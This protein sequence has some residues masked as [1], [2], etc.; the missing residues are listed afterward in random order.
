MHHRESNHLRAGGAALLFMGAASAQPV[1]PSAWATDGW[2]GMSGDGHRP[3]LVRSAPPS[4]AAPAWMATHDETD[5]PINFVAQAGLV[6]AP[7]GKFNVVVAV[8][9]VSRPG[10]PANRPRLFAFSRDEGAAVWSA[11]IPTPSFDSL[12]TPVI[13]PG[14]ETVLCASG[15]FVTAFDLAT[16]G[17]LWQRLL[18]RSVVNASPCV[19]SDLGPAD[20]L[21]ITTFDGG[22]TSA[23]LYC[24]NVDPFDAD[25][26]PFEP[27]EVVWSA[28]IGGSSGNSPAYLPA[29]L[30][31][32]GLV[33]VASVGHSQ[34]APGRV[35]AYPV[36]ETEPPAPAW[37]F[38]LAHTQGFFGGL[39]VSPGLGGAAPAVYAATYPFQG[40]IDDAHLVKLDA[41]TG[42]LRWAV[43]CNRSF[44]TPVV[45]PGGRIV[46]S[47]GI[48]FDEIGPTV[49]MFQDMGTSAYQVWDTALSTWNEL[50]DDGR[51]DI[52]EYFAVGGWTH[53]PV[54]C[55]FGGHTSLVSGVIEVDT[56]T[57]LNPR[58]YHLDLNRPPESPGFVL[59]ESAGAG[60]SP[61]FA[62]T[63][64]YSVGTAG[65]V[66]FGP[67]P[68]GL[69]VDRDGERTVDDLYAWECGVGFR[70]VNKDGAVDGGD[71]AMLIAALRVTPPVSAKAVLP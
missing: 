3:A 31:G 60:G 23:K 55:V 48:Y 16:G 69:D 15:R 34:L 71:R 50:D 19:T 58:L 41:A 5:S 65:L 64:M 14:N 38:E 49:A 36:V 1:P 56:F 20:R 52:G 10:E 6:V 37:V 51:L 17:Q 43:G 70:D 30:G 13:D 11:P 40:W 63:A 68:V 62:G 33:Y 27:G 25:L 47:G 67:T 26:N 29:A 24:L 46:L 57:S 59:D 42:A 2:L 66:A 61:A 28:P 54:A 53:Q 32:I 21:F 8:G 22:G 39:A 45:T 7:A 44:S 18:D 12:S 4:L 35:Y 9:R